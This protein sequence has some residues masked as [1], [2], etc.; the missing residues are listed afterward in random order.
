MTGKSGESFGDESGK[1]VLT[2][3]AWVK[4]VNDCVPAVDEGVARLIA[5]LKETGQYDNTLVVYSAD[6]GF[7]MGEHGFRTKLAPYEANYRSPLIVAM[8][9]KL[10]QGR[11]VRHPVNG[12]DIVAT[13]CSFA[14]ITPSWTLQGR[15]LT[16]LLHNTEADWNPAC[17]YEFTG[18]HYGS[19]VTSVI[20]DSPKEATYHSVPWYSVVVDDHFKYIR[21][22]EPGV[23]DELYDLDK[24]PEEL[25]N[26]A[27]NAA[28]AATLTQ[29]REKLQAQWKEL[30]APFASHVPTP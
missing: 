28:H 12:A 20:Q 4:Q 26:L 13:F 21:Y 9:S 14:G 16:P 25:V 30:K 8:P 5:T 23:T 3:D 10:P 29:M 11:F 2:F 22:L 1:K 15:D 27:Q 18:D 17:Y 7:A 24:D 6:Q 19:D